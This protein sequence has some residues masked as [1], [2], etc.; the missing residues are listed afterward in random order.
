MIPRSVMLDEPVAKHHQWNRAD[1]NYTKHRAHEC[2]DRK[3]VGSVVRVGAR[4]R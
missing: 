2:K 1:R 3:W 4:R